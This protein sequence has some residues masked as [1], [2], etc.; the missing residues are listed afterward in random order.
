MSPLGMT[1][2][3][4]YGQRRP[5][6]PPRALRLNQRTFAPDQLLVMAV[7][8]KVTR[9]QAAAVECVRAVLAEGADIVGIGGGPSRPGDEA[10]AREEIRHTIPFVAAVRDAY[11]DV[12][13]SVDVGRHE[14]GREACAAGADLLTY[15]RGGQEAGLAEVAAEFGA[16]LV[17]S[18]A[19][20]L[21]PGT[22]DGAL[23]QVAHAVD[24]GVDP[25]RILIAPGRD[26]GQNGWP[27]PETGQRLAELVA[28]GWPVMVSLSD[29]DFAGE[30]T[31]AAVDER[32]AGP[33]DERLAGPLDE[34]L[35]GPL[36]ERLAG[37]LDE[38]LAG[39]LDERLAGPLAATAVCAWLGARVFRV[40]H[41]RQ[42][43]RVLR[44]VAA[45]RG[46]IPPAYAVRGLA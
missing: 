42:T 39:P 25:A 32:L 34:R 27:S 4:E 19:G 20:Q 3:S 37:P 16:G 1:G 24:A 2:A 14:V 11:P 35:A 8:T 46:D 40:R 15:S 28:T 38:R 23:A 30:T 33:L 12:V 17:C 45:I 44:M 6:R 21:S 22:P 18:H 26:F 31:G 41:V 7:V 5:A 9:D 13:I 29:Q 10:E 36:D 43:R